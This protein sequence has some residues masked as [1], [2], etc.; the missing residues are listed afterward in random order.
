MVE[1]LERISKLSPKRLALLAMDLQTKL[2]TLEQARK[3]PIAIIGMGCRFPGDADNP[4]AFWHLLRHGVDAITEVPPERWDVDAYYDPNPDTPGKMNTRY[5]GFMKGIDRFDSHFFGIAPREVMSMDPQQRLL[6][7]VSWEALEHAGQSPEKL[8]GSRTGVFIG[9]CG[10]DYAQLLLEQGHDGFDAYL[11]T[12]SSHA[13]ASGRLSYVLGLHGPS[14]SIDTACSSSLV[15]VHFACQTL[16]TGGCRVA[17]AGGVNLILSPTTGITLSKSHMMA[18]DGRC[19]AFDAAADGFVRGEG[20]GIVVLKRLSDAIADGDCVLALIQG[21]AVNQ[22]GRSSG[23]TAPNG[24]AQEVVIREALAMARIEPSQVSYVETH[25][26]GTSLGDPIEVNALAAVLGNGRALDQPLRIGSVKTNIG[27]LEGAAG[28]AGLIKLVLA[29]QHKHIPPH[30]HLK[31]RNPY[32]P[33]EQLPIDI[34]TQLTPWSVD[35]GPR[36][37]AVS[38]FGFSGTNAHL[39]VAEA[40]VATTPEADVERP[41][42]LFTLSAKSEKALQELADRYQ[43]H[44][45]GNTSESLAHICFSANTGRGH[46]SHRLAMRVGSTAELQEN[47]QHVASGR[48][49]EGILEGEIE[50]NHPDTVFLFTGQGAQYVHMGRKL[51]DTQSTFRKTIATCD[52][53]LRPFLD[54]PLISVLY[55]EAGESSPVDQTAYTQPALFAVEYALATLWRSWGVE[56]AAVMG[57]SVG[58]YVAAC[59]AGVFSLEDGLRLIAERGRLMQ[60]LP[61]NGAMAV[62]FAHEARVAQAIAAYPSDLAVAAINGPDNVVISGARGAVEEVLNRFAAEGVKHQRL[63]VS[64]AFHSPLMD[65]ILDA[66]EQTAASV[67]FNAPTI[68]FISNLTGEIARGDTV[69]QATYW[70]RHVRQAVRFSSGMKTLQQQ[71][72]QLFVEVGP[73]PALLGMASKC[74]PE[75]AGVWLPSLRKGRDDWQQMLQTLGSLYVHGVE[76]DLAGF[77]QDYPRRKVALPTYPFQRERYWINPPTSGVSQ[78]T[79]TRPASHWRQPSHPLLGR[80]L[81]GP[82]P[83]FEMQLSRESLAIMDQHCVYGMAVVPGAAYLDL[84][85]AAAVEAFGSGAHTLTD[86]VIQEA[87]VLPPEGARTAQLIITPTSPEAASWQLFS[88]DVSTTDQPET[89]RLHASGNI[90]IRHDTA[91]AVVGAQLAVDEVQRRCVE[92]SVD[93]YYETLRQHGMGFFPEFQHIEKLWRR[94]GETL[95][96]IRLDDAVGV[97]ASGHR[98]PVTVL[99]TCLQL[100]AAAIPTGSPQVTDGTPYMLMGVERYQLFR[101][102]STHLWHH[103]LLGKGSKQNAQTF[104]GNIELFDADG[105][106]VAKIDGLHLKQVSPEALMRRQE[107]IPDWLYEVK[108]KA[109]AR[110][111]DRR[112]VDYIPALSQVADGVQAQIGRLYDEYQLVSYKALL[113]RLDTVCSAYAIQAFAELGWV[114]HLHQRVTT[115]GLLQQLRVLPSHRRLLERLLG[116]LQEDSVLRSVD[117][118]TW[119]VCR[120][121]QG[122]ELEPD[123]TALLE[124]FPACEAELTMIRRCGEHLASALRGEADPLQLLF[125]GG[126]LASAEQLYQEAPA[127]KTFNLLIKKAV[128]GA[129]QQ[130]PGARAMRVL[131]IGGGTGGTTSHV[132]PVLPA[133]RTDYVFTDIGQLFIAKAAQK[134][135]QYPFVRYEILDIGT[136]PETQGFL[137]HQ[138]DLIIAANVLHATRDVCQTLAHVRNLLAPRGLLILLEGTAPQRFSDLTVG[139]TEGWWSFADTDLRPS[140]A[141]L[142]E[143]TWRQVLADMHFTDVVMIPEG[144]ARQGILQTQAVILA[145]GP[146]VVQGSR[147]TAGTEVTSDKPERWM[148]FADENG[149]GDRLAELLRARGQTVLT[150]TAGAHYE[151][152]TDHAVTINPERPE[153][154]HRLFRE[155]PACRGVIHLWAL[156]APPAESMTIDVLQGTQ[157]KGLGSVLSLVQAMVLADADRRPGLWLITRGA[158]SIGTADHA[159]AV[160][161]ASLWGLGKV[162]AMEH[163]EIHCKRIDL[164]PRETSGEVHNLCE[165]ICS[166]DAEDQVAFRDDKRYVARL[167]HS[168][169]PQSTAAS[170]AALFDPEGTYLITGGLAGLGLLVAQWMV[171][172]GARHLVLL[173]RS[174][175]SDAARQAICALERAG[176]HVVVEAADVSHAD[177]MAHIFEHID[178]TMPPLRGLVHSAG[179]LDDGVLL[180]HNWQRFTHVLAPKVAGSW[181]LHNLT[182]ERVLD[183]FV[184]FSSGASLVGSPGQGNHAS[185]NA[186]MDALAYHRRAQ[187]LPALSINWGAW[188]EVGA[189]AKQRRDNRGMQRH[190]HFIAPQQGLHI[191]EQLLHQSPIQIGV[192]PLTWTDMMEPF[193][194]H[195]CPVFLSELVQDEPERSERTNLAAPTL[196]QELEN[197]P[198]SQGWNLMQAYVRGQVSRV[199]GLAPSRPVPLQQPLSELGLDSL[200]AL[201][202]RNAIGSAVGRTFPA[203]L[204][205]D[206]PTLEDLVAYIGRD[207]LSLDSLTVS[208]DAVS[209]SGALS[210]ETKDKQ[211]DHLSEHEMAVLLEERLNMV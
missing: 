152:K 71:D 53:L 188:S 208:E 110:Q 186:F 82:V 64:H 139:L 29:L 204:L 199:L 121:P 34:P 148:I 39:V 16:R 134:F 1:F 109:K 67:T 20:C 93:L 125:P 144:E 15:A 30:L 137:P 190:K 119:E 23:I 122:Q 45:A 205:F 21:S 172:Q 74:L 6:L 94:D 183:F 5:G 46:F 117:H 123:V 195:G 192:L 135:H 19:K 191:F 179:V 171:S 130:L 131:E 151:A 149:M 200:M 206:H 72:Y 162:I 56:P 89:W 141:L 136:E 18:A 78:H 8:E 90:C 146:E 4:S 36:I 41:S 156:D 9:I 120:I 40:P 180:Q 49:P 98:L 138:F 129:L 17:L 97:A 107:R 185:A 118:H 126:S 184:L 104:A 173:G 14:L 105:H 102:P 182:K 65:P 128:A 209:Q 59:V 83:I 159:L 115:D 25:G 38:S 155:T 140:Y 12:G 143:A 210:E 111:G 63:Q 201:E 44:L 88:A 175:A 62:V 189:A 165:E 101:Q 133:D 178:R 158:Q 27:H 10:T 57:H 80:R 147:S 187:G 100:L 127:Y 114:F 73:S 161:H 116:M 170:N 43:Q 48:K 58:E 24:P 37:G 31:R 163:H 75:G 145:R 87:I 168:Q 54:K 50:G 112:P 181:I 76:V 164:A 132:L 77:D 96:Y 198:S 61:K 92:E 153:D 51:Y 13:I 167:V 11:A 108:W 211:L 154:F 207:V 193:G 157:R 2:D 142:S 79:V 177:R 35:Q 194:E 28:V 68:E 202:L 86:V 99:D 95:G 47:L 197:A 32:L 42:H 174:G 7:E 70:R 66:F 26:T 81:R 22:D 196:L 203:T 103:A 113:P 166:H 169:P 52:E 91:G 60:A 85:L 160:P 33:W 84:V 69:T 3:E 55:P 106:L 124:Q 176:A 150:V